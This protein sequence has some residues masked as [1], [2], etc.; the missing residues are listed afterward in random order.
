MRDVLLKA[1]EDK[2]INIVGNLPDPHELT[3]T[4]VIGTFSITGN[5]QRYIIRDADTMFITDGHY[6]PS[7]IARAY[8]DVVFPEQL[9]ATKAQANAFRDLSHAPL[10]VNPGFMRSGAYID[11]K[12]AYFQITNL[13]GW[14]VDYMPGKFVSPGRSVEDFPMPNHKIARN[15]LVTSGLPGHIQM[16]DG[17][18]IVRRWSNNKHVNLGLMRLIH[19]V[20]N[21]FAVIAVLEYGAKYVNTDGCI[22]H[23]HL[24]EDFINMLQM[25]L[26]L[27]AEVKH[28][29]ETWITGPGS[30]KVGDYE[31]K[32]FRYNTANWHDSIVIDDYSLLNSMLYQFSIDRVYNEDRLTYT[33]VNRSDGQTT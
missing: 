4:S 9:R 29:G 12:S 33:T 24:A 23:N 10:Y 21:S 5:T 11:I 8:L 27:V 30:Y 18:R 22:I 32:S 28:W 13:V 19:D 7:E 2:N 1:N 31:T 16:W 6:T 25:R 14:N 26:G 17:E 3:E 15:C 20:L